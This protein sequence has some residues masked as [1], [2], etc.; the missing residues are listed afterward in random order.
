[1]QPCYRAMAGVRFRA[2]AARSPCVLVR[3]LNYAEKGGEAPMTQSTA[4][5]P[6]A[7]MVDNDLVPSPWKT[8]FDNEEWLVHRIVVL[9]T[10]AMVVIVLIAHLLV[11]MWRPWL[12]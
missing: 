3:F 5:R 7:E 8:L 2:P 6:A 1:M 9:S 12:G 4:T 10:Y 11:W